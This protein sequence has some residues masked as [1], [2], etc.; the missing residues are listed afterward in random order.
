MH[1]EMIFF[2]NVCLEESEHTKMRLTVNLS[3]D[4]FQNK[5]YHVQTSDNSTLETSNGILKSGWV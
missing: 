2:P 4:I 1:L 3:D 5:I